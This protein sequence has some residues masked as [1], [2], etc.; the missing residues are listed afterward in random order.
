[1]LEFLAALTLAASPAPPEQ[2]LRLETLGEPA[3]S[4]RHEAGPGR[5]VL[6]VH[7]STFPSGLSIAYH[8][9]GKSWAADLVARGFDVWS[10]DLPGY[11]GSDRPQAMEFT[12]V[13][14][15]DVPGRATE[16]AHQID[17]VVRHIQAQTKQQKVSIIAHS[18]GTIPACLFVS[19]HPDSVASLVLFG[20]V[21]ARH[22]SARPK[23]EVE[24]SVLITAEH[25]WASFQAG[26]P[27]GQQSL[28][29]RDR[30]DAWVAAYLAT[31]PASGKRTP[32]AVRVPAGPDVD[33]DEA[34]SGHL[35]YDPSKIRVP[36][37]IVRGEW[38]A[39]TRDGDA[40][41]LVKAMTS[42][43]GGARDV[44]LPRGGHRMHLEENRGALF[45]AVGRFLKDG[46]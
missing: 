10:F 29:P 38:D 41:W 23:G 5:S 12:K 40:A 9:D 32:P 27:E 34:W 13:A 30:F 7:G 2:L 3:L 4:V 24:P 21:A 45:D 18:W 28:I 15:K 35:P 11:G 20:P 33:F 42:V 22:G 25:Q 6:F 36:T 17:R 16:A 14:A 44:K 43:P 1:M 8:I 26:L 37:L 46:R 39:I 19:T 31:D